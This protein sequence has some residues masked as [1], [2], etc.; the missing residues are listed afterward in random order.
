M[1]FGHLDNKYVTPFLS[2]Q[3]KYI[4][5]YGSSSNSSAIHLLNTGWLIRPWISI[6]V[7]V[8]YNRMPLC[9]YKIM[10]YTC[11]FNFCKLW[12]KYIKTKLNTCT[13]VWMCCD[14]CGYHKLF[15]Y[16]TCIGPTWKSTKIKT[17]RTHTSIMDITFNFT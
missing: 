14:Q 13:Y 6:H 4:S 5:A 16:N 9:I 12:N 2:T 17:N 3:F 7:C 15:I 1:N 10:K 11:I 8:V